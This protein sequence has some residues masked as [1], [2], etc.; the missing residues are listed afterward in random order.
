VHVFNLMG[1][2]DGASIENP[3]LPAAYTVTSND[4]SQIT[5]KIGCCDISTENGSHNDIQQFHSAYAAS[6]AVNG[7]NVP[8]IAIRNPLLING[9]T[10]TRSVNILRVSLNCSKKATF[11]GWGTRDGSALTGGTILGIDTGSF[12]ECDSPQMNPLA[13]RSTGF[14]PATSGFVTALSVE[15]NTRQVWENPNKERLELPLARGDYLII[16]CTATTATADVVVE[17][18]E[19]V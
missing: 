18:G 7:T 8:V 2:L 16:T 1:T 9:K 13:V 4:G 3:A 12:I 14:T 15:A 19:A 5:M 6:V 11:I 17:W 10:N